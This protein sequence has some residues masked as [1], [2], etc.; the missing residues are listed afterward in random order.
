MQGDPLSPFLFTL[1]I[2]HLGLSLQ[3]KIE[4]EQLK[5]FKLGVNLVESYLIYVDDLVV[6]SKTAKKSIGAVIDNFKEHKRRTGL[7]LNQTKSNI[8]LSKICTNQ[9]SLLRQTSLPKECSVQFI[10]WS[11]NCSEL[12]GFSHI[13]VRCKCQSREYMGSFYYGSSL[14]ACKI[15]YI[16]LDTL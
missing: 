8:S 14:Q 6:F 10:P 11:T 12:L 1:A 15:I 7:L 3:S 13:L 2:E 4:S 5:T 9:T 16:L